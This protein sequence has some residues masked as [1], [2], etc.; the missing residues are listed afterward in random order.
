MQL[1][2]G[3]VV[4]LN[5]GGPDCLVVDFEGDLVVAAWRDRSAKVHEHAW[6]ACCLTRVARGRPGPPER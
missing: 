4:R 6:P 2:I 1:A 5:S 3:D